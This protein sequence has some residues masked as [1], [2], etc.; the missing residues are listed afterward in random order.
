MIDALEP[1]RLHA[2]APVAGFTLMNADTNQPVAAYKRLTNGAVID[3]SKLPTRNLSIRANVGAARPGSVKF[4]YDANSSYSIENVAAYDMAG[5][6]NGDV[7]PM[8][9]SA[10]SVGRHVVAATPYAL[11]K[12]AG[13]AGA[14]VT[15]SFNV[16]KSITA[17]A[18]AATPTPAP[19]PAP[20]PTPA[21]PPSPTLSPAAAP[22]PVIG[23]RT[24]VV[25][26]GGQYATIMSAF[27]VANAGDVVL[28]KPGAYDESLTLNRSGTS[29]KPIT[30]AAESPGTVT[31]D[32]NRR[33]FIV[34]G[35]GE[36][37]RLSGITFEDARNLIQSPAVA[38][39]AGWWMTDCIVQN[40]DS[41]G[42]AVFGDHVRL[43][44]VIA[45]R[46]GQIGLSGAGCSDV[47]VKDCIS[48]NNNYGMVSPAWAGQAHSVFSND[49]WY[50][51]G[52]WESGG[53]K[54]F[55]TD[56]VTIDGMT[57]CNNFGAGLVFDWNNTNIVVRNSHVYNNTGLHDYEG[58]GIQIEMNNIGPALVENNLVHG[59]KGGD[60]VVRSSRNVILRSNTIR[61]GHLLLVDWFRGEG[62]QV[63]N[64]SITSNYLERSWVQTQSPNWTV[65]SGKE[66]L[67]TIHSNRYVSPQGKLFR[68][69]EKDYALLKDVQT[70][71][72][73]EWNG[74][75]G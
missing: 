32:A 35:W 21:P 5:G 47:I 8:P 19:A 64:V 41:Q 2:V 57:A 49:L 44:R 4:G 45:Q 27:N 22:A 71:L 61:D 52:S 73:F 56:H 58:I 75:V 60:I 24:L 12:A 29:V 3:L 67:I 23:G 13:A 68:W 46:N 31:V 10:F 34:K 70:L 62:Y 43:T 9:A 25:S 28:I 36:H 48:R 11:A 63:R 54:W 17:P 65:N 38:V 69:G 40:N 20:L 30:L 7:L 55:E 26:K 72:G 50:A 6:N 15:V 33:D 37:I 53:G 51:D 42:I 66:K 39:G 1:R 74:W 59:N 14:K 18:P 16:I